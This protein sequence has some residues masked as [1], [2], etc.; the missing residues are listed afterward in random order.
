MVTVL[1][2]GELIR[3]GR[4]EIRLHLIDGGRV[5]VGVSGPGTFEIIPAPDDED[6][7]A[8][9]QRDPSDADTRLMVA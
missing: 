3:I 5:T 8:F 7:I 9:P 1:T 4:A 6:A 2:S